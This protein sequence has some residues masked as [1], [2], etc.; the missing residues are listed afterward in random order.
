[1]HEFHGVLGDDVGE[2]ENGFM[3][4]GRRSV[5]GEALECVCER[6]PETVQP[7]AMTDDAIALHVVEH[8]IC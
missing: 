6:M 3:H 7:V 5:D 2:A 1:V 8:P 4:R